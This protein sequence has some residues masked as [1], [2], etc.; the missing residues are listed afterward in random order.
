MMTFKAALRL[1]WRVFTTLPRV[2][3]QAVPCH[4]ALATTG[5]ADRFSTLASMV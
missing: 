4:Q 3:I 5:Q 2:D 1:L